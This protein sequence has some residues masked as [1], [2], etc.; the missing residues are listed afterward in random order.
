MQERI[1]ELRQSAVDTDHVALEFRN[2]YNM[3]DAGG[4]RLLSEQQLTEANKQLVLA[5]SR[6]AEAKARLDRILELREPRGLAMPP[7]LTRCRIPCSR[8]CSSSMLTP[9]VGTP[10][11]DGAD[12]PAAVNVR[13]DMDT[14]RRVSRD[15]VTRIAE[16]LSHVAV[17]RL[18][19]HTR[20]C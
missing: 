3:V 9:R 5:T 1:V 10:N 15:E 17:R 4:G 12:H 6:T 11:S 7:W 13:K 19:R 16:S 18:S 2:K 8:D 14:I 20:T